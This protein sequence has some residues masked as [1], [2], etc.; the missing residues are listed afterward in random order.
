[1]HYSGSVSRW[2]SSI[3]QS[4]RGAAFGSASADH[5]WPTLA[6]NI[7]RPVVRYLDILSQL[8][9]VT[10]SAESVTVKSDEIKAAPMLHANATEALHVIESR[11]WSEI[12]NASLCKGD[13]QRQRRILKGLWLPVMLLCRQLNRKR[14]K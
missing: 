7:G 6:P 8:T 4:L 10:V 11:N 13:I 1:M 2:S 5:P 9:T 12:T 14:V 3:V